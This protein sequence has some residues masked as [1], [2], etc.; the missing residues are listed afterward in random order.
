MIELM[1]EGKKVIFLYSGEGTHS[2]ET[3]LGLLKASDSY[4]EIKDIISLKLALNLDQIW[5]NGLNDHSGPISPLLTVITEIC[6]ADYWYGWGYEP[7]V[8]IGHSTGE[9]AAAYQA[10]FYTLEE[11]LQLAYNIGKAASEIEGDMYHGYL[12]ES[13]LKSLSVPLGSI[14]FKDDL[15]THVTICGVKDELNS[16]LQEKSEFIKMKVSHPWHHP[17]YRSHSA[18]LVQKPSKQISKH[19]F[20]SGVTTRFEDHLTAEH[21]VNWLV[22]P[23]DLYQSLKTIKQEF[24][25]KEFD[26]IE[27]GFHPVLTQ[28]C[29]VFGKYNYASSM[30]RGEDDVKWMLSQRKK[31]SQKPVTDKVEQIINNYNQDLDF[32]TSLAYQDLTS[33]NFVELTALLQPFFPNLAPQDFYRFESIEKLLNAYGIEKTV[34][35]SGPVNQQKNGVVIAGMSCRMPS[36]V[37]T[38]E[39]FWEMLT[40]K[41]DQ[42]KKQDGRGPNE[43]GFLNQRMTRFDHQ[44]FNISMAE[45]H[46]M[47]PQQILALELTEL[48]WRDAKIDPDKLNRKR[49]GVY[50]GAWNDEYNGDKTS[51]FFPTGTNPSIIASRISYHYDLRGPSWVANTACSS[52]LVAIHYA[53]KDIE[54]GRIDYAIA[55]GVNMLLDENFSANMKNSGFLSPDNRCKTFDDSANGYV[56]AEGGG[57]VLLANQSLTSKYYAQVLGSSINQNGGRPQVITAPHPEAQE[58]L[59]VDACQDAGITPQDIQYLE[60]HGTGT[61][62]GDPI[63]MSA[64]QNTV[65]KGRNNTCYVGSIKS[66]L[67]HLESAAGIAGLL[68]VVTTLVHGI[69]PPNLH[70]KQPNQ[71]IDFDSHPIQVVS[72]E[73][74][75]NHDATTGLSSFGF[76]G[77][78]AHIVIKGA[79]DV[80]RKSIEKIDIPFDREKAASLSQYLTLLNSESTQQ[81]GLAETIATDSQQDVTELVKSLFFNLTGVSDIEPDI[82]LID[83]GLDSMS[84]TELTNQL[85]EDLNIDI[86][87]DI[88]FDHPLFDQFV[89]AIEQKVAEQAGSE[90]SKE[91]ITKLVTDLFFQLTGIESIDSDLELTD[92][93]LDSLSATE[94]VSKLETG[95]N[96]DLDPDI[97]FEFPLPDQF[98]DKIFE[99]KNQG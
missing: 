13:E 59:I 14:N 6:L 42:V 5:E 64:L 83:Q 54:A 93:G 51:V 62:I 57:L 70:F 74:P 61:K 36:R 38:L 68:K 21:W 1:E 31:L 22:T 66:N 32:S 60:S 35:S 81:T 20:V 67:G 84:A 15:G 97:L 25:D 49:V 24:P 29:Q 91:K 19:L 45:A 48:L 72:E 40:S 3:S 37:E 55:G 95:L 85:C 34:V 89:E 79:S 11:T 63:E 92:Q 41:E 69:I 86:E 53:A 96:I 78:N 43:A 33:L 23:I 7:D 90:N 76:G 50:I 56:R 26:I 77:S 4:Q 75:I 28:S 98:I 18:D 58:E 94:L 30:Y 88:F 10:G 46:T 71:Y 44:Y 16:F 12:S 2:P 80:F 73:T 87:A 52:S 82:E 39:Q 8:V 17:N 65:G 99:V 27:I 47:D 9:L